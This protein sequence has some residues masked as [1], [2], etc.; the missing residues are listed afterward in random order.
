MLLGLFATGF[1][2][3]SLYL[4]LQNLNAE[5][6]KMNKH[7]KCTQTE[8]TESRYVDL[9]FAINVL[10]NNDLANWNVKA[11][12]KQGGELNIK[13]SGSKNDNDEADDTANDTESQSSESSSEETESNDTSSSESSSETTSESTEVATPVQQDR[14]PQLILHLNKT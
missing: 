14:H 2:S 7:N 11:E 5:E 8:L 4:F 3:Y 13:Y 6:D 9:L 1:L 12:F 10:K